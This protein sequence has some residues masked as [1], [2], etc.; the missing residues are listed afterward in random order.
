MSD[1]THIIDYVI[2]MS[3]ALAAFIGRRLHLRIDHIDRRMQRVTDDT[4]KHIRRHDHELAVHREHVATGYVRKEEHAE[5]RS[6]MR[7]AFKEV[8]GKLDKISDKI[9][10]KAD[11]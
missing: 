10:G 5:F 2:A 7:D 6:E 3:M 1:L 4:Q 8:S 9:D 11:K